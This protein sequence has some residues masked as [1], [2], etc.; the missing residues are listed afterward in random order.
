[1][2]IVSTG[3]SDQTIGTMVTL[4]Q[5][6][7]IDKQIKKAMEAVDAIYTLGF[8]YE[9]LNAITRIVQYAARQSA[10]MAQGIL[11]LS[12]ATQEGESDES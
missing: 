10:S 11:A 2:G 1:M 12:D 9:H 5:T 7:T 8:T 3:G 6:T 4:S